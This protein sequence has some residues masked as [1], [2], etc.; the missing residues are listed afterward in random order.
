MQ[1][2]FMLCMVV[3]RHRRGKKANFTIKLP[4]ENNNMDINPEGLFYFE[5]FPGVWWLAGNLDSPSQL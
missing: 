2:V 4:L 1:Q 3:A 5:V